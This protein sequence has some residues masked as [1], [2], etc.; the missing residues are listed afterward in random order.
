MGTSAIFSLSNGSLLSAIMSA[1][2][3]PVEIETISNE[4]KVEE[5]KRKS[6]DADKAAKNGDSVEANG[7]SDEPVCKKSKP[8]ETETDGKD[9]V[10]KEVKDDAEAEDDEADE[11]NGES[12]EEEDSED[13]SDADE[14]NGHDEE[15]GDDKAEG[16][17]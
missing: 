14:A 15:S 2:A 4:K 1:E 13:G 9:E 16:D 6:L 7:D 12:A 8:Q 17:E 5:L 10:T 11:E 3:A